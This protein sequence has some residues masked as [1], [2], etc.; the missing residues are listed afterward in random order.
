MKAVIAVAAAVFVLAACSE[1]APEPTPTP[2][3]SPTPTVAP[4]PIPEPLGTLNLNASLTGQD[5]IGR[6]NEAEADCIRANLDDSFLSLPFNTPVAVPYEGPVIDRAL[7]NAVFNC[8]SAESVPILGVA[9]ADAHAGGW[10]TET[11]TCISR[12]VTANPE[13][14]YVWLGL[15]REPEPEIRARI[16]SAYVYALQMWECFEDQ[17]K[18]DFALHSLENSEG[19]TGEELIE[20]VLNADELACLLEAIPEESMKM[21]R[22]APSMTA[23]LTIPGVA[24][25]VACVGPDINNRLFVNAYA[26]LTGGLSEEST[27]CIIEFSKNYPDFMRLA[28]SSDFDPAS[29]PVEELVAVANDGLRLFGCLNDAE[30]GRYQETFADR[31]FE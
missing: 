7:M 29:M 12:I 30:L 10:V 27:A 18:I 15:E 25:G 5:L 24:A 1:D 28:Q 13:I 11:R 9:I 19:A 8:L 23:A 21:L 6:L 31:W 2:V 20:Q 3:P 4:T 26:K 16:E 14:I 17:E 22:E